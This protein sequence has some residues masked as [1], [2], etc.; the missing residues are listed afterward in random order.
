MGSPLEGSSAVIGPDGRILS[1]RGKNEELLF[2]DLDLAEI[3]K[4]K[5][6]ADASGHCEYSRNTLVK[7]L[8]SMQIAVQICSGS[9]QTARRNRWCDSSRILQA[10][11]HTARQS[12]SW[13]TVT[14][15]DVHSSLRLYTPPD[16]D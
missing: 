15:E 8:M 5:T 10:P 3:V 14:G 11:L 7:S 13:L 2:A 1:G 12:S 16:L 4:A 9:G 6:F